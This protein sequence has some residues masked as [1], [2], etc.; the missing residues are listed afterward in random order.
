MHCH[1]RPGLRSAGT[2]IFALPAPAV[3]QDFGH[4][5]H[6]LRAAALQACSFVALSSQAPF[7]ALPCAG[8]TISSR[9]PG[10]E[11]EGFSRTGTAFRVA[12]LPAQPCF[13]RSLFGS[14]GS[15]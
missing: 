7:P 8:T 5:L 3:T 9:T 6:R 4:A 14:F 10:L 13:A 1:S 12:R 11:P 2:V 15:T